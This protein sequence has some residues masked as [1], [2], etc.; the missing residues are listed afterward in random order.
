MKSLPVLL[1]GL[2]LLFTMTG[3]FAAEPATAPP[4]ATPAP[5]NK[6]ATKT[7]PPAAPVEAALPV[8]SKLKA[9][10]YFDALANGL[11]LTDPEKKEITDIYEADGAAIQK[12]GND[13]S[14]S[15][16]Q[17]A[18][19]IA[20]L[21]DTRNSK[22]EDILHDIDRKK[23]FHDVEVVYRVDVTVIALDGQLLPPPPPAPAIPAPAPA[24]APT[25]A[26]SEPAPAAKPAPPA[27][28]APAATP[29]PM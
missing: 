11:S 14:L 7:P 26:K 25:P 24:A 8:T 5:T 23:A 29:P 21:R 9:T 19:Q 1:G 4:P 13:A 18:Q 15:S 3:S 28:N 12:I 20:D 16:L 27:T 10:D 22:I 2:L 6:P 17:K